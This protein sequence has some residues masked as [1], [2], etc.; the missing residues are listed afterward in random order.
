M[1]FTS[2]PA[3]GED[4]TASTLQALIKE[5]RPVFVRKASDETVNNSSTLQNDDELLAA[6]E[7]NAVYHF[8]LR[9]TVN[10][11]T[12]PDIKVGFTYPTSTTL[13]Y[14][15]M[16]GETPSGAA[17]NVLTGP[18]TQADAAVAFST[19]GSDQPCWIEGLIV[20][21]STPG[22]FQVQWAQ[23]AATASNTIVRAGSYLILR[24][25]S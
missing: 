3:A 25:V 21:S 8:K 1:A 14:D 13:T 16:E 5:L 15:I 7:A 12:T 22:T 10:S 23:F 20:V 9:L 24:R 4:L 17:A 18:Y 19:T 11:G 2:Y 6:V